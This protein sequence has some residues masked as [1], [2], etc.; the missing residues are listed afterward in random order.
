MFRTDTGET[1]SRIRFSF[2]LI[3]LLMKGRS[4]PRPSILLA[5]DHRATRVAVAS[6]LE[7]SYNVVGAVGD[8]LSLVEPIEKLSPDVAVVD[9][10]MPRMTG[11]Q[12]ALQ[13]RE[14]KSKTRVVFLT[15]QGNPEF[16]HAAMAAGALGYVLKY[17]LDSDLPLAIEA[18][19]AGQRFVSPPLSDLEF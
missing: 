18:A 8:G 19:L 9:I 11:L 15:L 1:P 17:R 14:M 13:M 4:F 12:A 16:L 2:P 6:F 7:A 3:Y 10:S 5:D